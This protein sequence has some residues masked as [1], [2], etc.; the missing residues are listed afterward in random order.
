MPAFGSLTVNDGQ[1]TPV[2]HAFA[3][4]SKDGYSSVFVDRSPVSAIGWKK[5][6]YQVIPQATKLA[7]NKVG[8]NIVDPA[9]ATVDGQVVKARQ[10]T[11]NVIFNFA[12]DATEQERKDLVA[13]TINSLSNAT[14]KDGIIKMEPMY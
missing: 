8:I 10:S 4:F 13:Y 14:V 1:T 5:L 9:L 3:P 11:A 6:T 2:A 7:A 12:P